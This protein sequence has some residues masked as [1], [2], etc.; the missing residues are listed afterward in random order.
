MH[1]YRREQHDNDGVITDWVELL[2]DATKPTLYFNAGNVSFIDVTV[3]SYQQTGYRYIY[4]AR[5]HQVHG[6]W[7]TF[8][9][10]ISAR[11]ND[12][13]K[14][15]GEF[16]VEQVSCPGVKEEFHGAFITNPPIYSIHSFPPPHHFYNRTALQT[17]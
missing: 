6:E 9:E 16:P 3:Q 10:Q 4:T 15:Q 11:I 14:I 12:E 13:Y 5:C 8:C 17:I 7:S 1:M 2:P